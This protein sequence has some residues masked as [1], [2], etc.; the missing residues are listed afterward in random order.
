MVKLTRIYT[1]GGDGGESGLVDGARLSKADPRF[2]AIGDVDEL[3]AA[4]GLARAALDEG[5]PAARTLA[6]IQNDL[7]DLGADLATPWTGEGDETALRLAPGR[8]QDLEAA[9][10]RLTDRLEPLS[11]FVLPGGTEASAR[12]HLARAV[13]RRA[14]RSVA[15]LAG[16][17]PLNPVVLAYLNRLSDLLFQMARA[18]NA[19][20]GEDIL[21]YPG[22]N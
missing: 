7:F 20:G 13:A 12:L 2:H 17:V 10:D 14:E 11:S 15:A 22:A 16:H 21:W 5:G 4:L 19:D 1:R 8:T 9:I 18:E 6:G 3:N